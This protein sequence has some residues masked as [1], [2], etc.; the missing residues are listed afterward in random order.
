M[1]R[2]SLIGLTGA[3]LSAVLVLSACSGPE[4]ASTGAG[5]VADEKVTLTVATFN[6]SGYDEL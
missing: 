2:R 3:T 1:Q 5:A 4:E 6:E